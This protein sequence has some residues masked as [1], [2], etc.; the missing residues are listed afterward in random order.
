M[1]KLLPYTLVTV[2]T[3]SMATPFLVHANQEN[4]KRVPPQ[5]AIDACSNK[6]AGDIC[7]FVGRKNNNKEGI[8]RKPPQQDK[9]V[10]VPNPP[11]QALEAC[12]D[13][14]EGDACSFIGRMNN[15]VNGSCKKRILG[16][17]EIVCK[18]E[19]FGKQSAP[20]GN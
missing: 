10:C 8:C 4:G 20:Q 6:N 16:E 9:L 18:P 15:T 2:L 7:S 13:K 11:P 5:Q 1:K 3:L 17:G 14:K 19:K 12:K